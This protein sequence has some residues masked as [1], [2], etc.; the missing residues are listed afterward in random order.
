MVWKVRRVVTGHDDD[1]KSTFLMDG[2]APNIKE[3]DLDAGACAD[4]SVG[5][6]NGAREQR[7]QRGRDGAAG[8]SRA[9]QRRHDSADCRVST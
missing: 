9:A 2:L 6:D 1:G 5:N 7:R 4:R 8:A 3:M